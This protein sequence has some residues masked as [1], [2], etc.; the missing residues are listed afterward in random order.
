MRL[1]IIGL[2]S[3]GKTT[4]FNALTRSNLPTGEMSGGDRV[5]VHTSAVDVP[6]ER[7]VEVSKIFNPK[8]TTTTK[9][10]YADIGGLTIGAGRDGLPGELVNQLEQVDGLLLVVRAF[11]NPAVPHPHGDLDPAR[12]VGQVMAEFIL[13]DMVTVERRLEKLEEDRQKGGRDKGEIER[14][15]ALF[16]RLM[17]VLGG[18]E[19]LRDA[20]LTDEE[21]QRVG[22][23]GLLSLISI[24]VVYNTSEEGIPIGPVEEQGGDP[25]LLVHGKIEMEI[26]QLPPEDEGDFLAEY[27]ISEPGRERVIRAS[28][29]TLGLL[30]FFTGND[31]EARAWTLRRGSTCLE[32]AD[33]IHSDMAR[34][35]IRAEVI[36]WDEL[37]A[38]GSLADARA[39]GKLRVEGKEYIVSDGD[40]LY[41]RFNV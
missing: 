20:D 12:D 33:T 10:T 21:R 32:A 24:L 29:D 37:V 14:E 34:G 8:K 38:L 17:E 2:P 27:G 11:E 19:P 26:A 7:L 40:V 22:G 23:F 4:L 16:T 30:T 6:D 18:D 9:V 39:Q 15:Q 1:G 25:L 28:Y 36:A 5:E 31:E 41:I 35:F 3:S 13:H